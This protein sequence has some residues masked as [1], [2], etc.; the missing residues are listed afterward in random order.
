MIV[1]DSPTDT[2]WA[3]HIVVLKKVRCVPTSTKLNAMT[4]PDLFPL[5]RIVDLLDKVEK[6][7]RLTKLH[8]AQGYHRIRT[9]DTGLVYHMVIGLPAY[10]PDFT[11]K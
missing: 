10:C 9:T 7:R 3:A 8:M 6:A 11:D 4:E 1:D 5:P 2:T